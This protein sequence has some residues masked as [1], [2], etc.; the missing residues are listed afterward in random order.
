MKLSVRSKTVVADTITPVAA[1]LRLRDRLPGCLLLEG[2]DYQ[3][4]KNS[5]SYICVDPLKTFSVSNGQIASY[6]TGERPERTEITDRTQVRTELKKFL[7]SFE[8]VGEVDVP[9]DRGVFGYC[10]Y[11][12]VRYFEEIDLQQVSKPGRE[13][14]DLFYQAFRFI[15]VFNPHKNELTVM[16]HQPESGLKSSYDIDSLL[17][18]LFHADYP[19]Y[20][21]RRKGEQSSNFTEEGFLDVVHACKKHIKRGDVFQIVPSRRYV[22]P[23]TGDD[24]CVYRALRSINPSPYLFFFDYGS[25]RIFGSSPEAQLVVRQDRAT[26]FPIAGTYKRTHNEDEDRAAIERLLEDEKEN[27]EHVML[28]DL[29][30]ND[31]SRHCYPV[32]VDSYKAVE[33]YSHV[34]HLTSRVSGELIPETNP[35][36][37]LF[38][39]FPMGTLSGAPKYR[40][41]ELLDQYEHGPRRAYGGAV[42]MLG[43][44]G[45]INHAIVI[46]SFHSANHELS[47]Q[48]GCGVVSDSVPESEAQEVR[49]KLAALQQALVL[50][51]GLDQ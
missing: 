11:D 7:A 13:I 3:P 46:R 16:E 1:Y 33:K 49:N 9:F 41:M 8:F 10:A 45:S 2:N 40:A 32:Q 17:Y 28:V 14:P 4:G 39:T 19:L 6:Y 26:L 27:A 36:D 50:A 31:L 23:Y 25:F 48:A 35:I 38:D 30:R 42:G 37:I 15:L 44:D 43:F 21:F 47:F 5:L 24:F 29:A 20:P 34:I 22:Q 18:L 51:E 12:A